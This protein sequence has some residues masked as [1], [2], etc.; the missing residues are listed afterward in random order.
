MFFTQKIYCTEHKKKG[1]QTSVNCNN[2]KVGNFVA[3]MT[4]S[5]EN[6]EHLRC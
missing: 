5:M 2:G 4:H 3:V 1:K 6:I